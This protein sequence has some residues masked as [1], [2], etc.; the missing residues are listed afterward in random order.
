MTQFHFLNYHCPAH[1]SQIMEDSAVATDGFA[2]NDA[3]WRLQAHTIAAAA[4]R[5][6]AVIAEVRK[7]YVDTAGIRIQY[8]N[9]HTAFAPIAVYP[10]GARYLRSMELIAREAEPFAGTGLCG[11]ILWRAQ[12]AAPEA[13]ALLQVCSHGTRPPIFTMPSCGT[14]LPLWQLGGRDA[15]RPDEIETVLGTVQQNAAFPTTAAL[16]YYTLSALRQRAHHW[17]G[18]GP[19]GFASPNEALSGVPAAGRSPGVR[20]GA[21]GPRDSALFCAIPESPAPWNLA[22]C[23]QSGAV[24]FS[25]N[26]QTWRSCGWTEATGDALIPAKNSDG[27]GI[28]G[29]SA[30]FA[31]ITVPS[32]APAGAAPITILFRAEADH[33]AE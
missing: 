2:S 19:S 17:I 25:L 24:A 7:H 21:A 12:F 31:E 6:L 3:V 28:Y 27:G 30:D 33:G 29:D 13:G 10:P 4:P 8:D 1:F 5:R 22:E 9:G 32:S 16:H 26:G 14:A 18:N 23:L 11:K 15:A 20:A